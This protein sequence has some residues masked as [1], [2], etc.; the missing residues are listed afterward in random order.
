MHE[1]GYGSHIAIDPFQESDWHGIGVVAVQELQFS[2]RFKWLKQRSD[3]ALTQMSADRVRAQYIYI[4]GYHT[5]DACLIDLCCSDQILDVGGL[6]ILD[7]VWMPSIKAVASFVLSN[8]PHFQRLEVNFDNILALEKVS[9]DTR[10]WDHFVSFNTG[11]EV[12][13]PSRSRWAVPRRGR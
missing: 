13:L 11:T 8:M 1:R 4:D 9:Q 2:D 12:P 10:S 7:D 3:F 5:F 6:I